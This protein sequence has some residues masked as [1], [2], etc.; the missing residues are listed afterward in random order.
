[1]LYIR[2]AGWKI[3]WAKYSRRKAVVHVDMGDAGE[4]RLTG[5]PEQTIED[6]IDVIDADALK[7]WWGG[8]KRL[9]PAT[10]AELILW[11]RRQLP[12]SI[13]ADGVLADSLSVEG[14]RDE[15]TPDRFMAAVTAFRHLRHDA[16]VSACR[17]ALAE[18]KEDAHG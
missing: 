1:M 4:M 6:I 14:L 8:K 17:R 13:V 2:K 7:E 15:D 18:V 11:R 9:G 10:V 3:L 16:R 12:G 5:K